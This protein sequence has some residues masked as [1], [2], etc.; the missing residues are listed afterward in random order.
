MAPNLSLIEPAERFRESYLQMV[1][2]LNEAGDLHPKS[3]DLWAVK[4][5]NMYLNRVRNHAQGIDFEQGWVSYSV[6]W[7]INKNNEVAG[8]VY[9]R[10]RLTPSLE[11]F[12]GHIGYAIAPSH[13][14]KRYGTAI[15]KFALEKA[16]LLG[17]KRALITCNSDNIASRKIIK[18][19]GGIFQDETPVEDSEKNSQRFWIDIK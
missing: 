15:L 3:P 11:K 9:I 2:E 8:L 17:I 10:Y 16:K 13:R 4:D 12:G 7:L 19:N 5:F 1:N 6:Y 14:R 18:T